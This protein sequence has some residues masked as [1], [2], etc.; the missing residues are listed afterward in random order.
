MRDEI[1]KVSSRTTFNGKT[2][3]D[4]T[5][6]TTACVM[7]QTGVTAADTVDISSLLVDVHITTLT[8]GATATA[9]NTATTSANDATGAAST[10][11]SLLQ[12]LATAIDTA[13]GAS[14]TTAATAVSGFSANYGLLVTAVDG[15]IGAIATVRSNFGA[16]QN[17]LDHNIANLASQAES[18]T[19]SMSR[20][21]DTD[22]SIE[23]AKLTKN[24]VMQQAA[25]A[26]LAQANQMPNGVLSLLK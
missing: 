5:Q 25:T 22:Y 20:I 1:N 6:S 7:F 12:T 8:G 14:V 3:L 4:G 26:M 13:A 16:T 10:V 15:A 23:T 24:Q 17:R 21:M 18:L 9:A 2:L 19:A 11:G